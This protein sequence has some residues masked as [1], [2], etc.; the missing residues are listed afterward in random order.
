VYCTKSVTPPVAPLPVLVAGDEEAAP[1]GVLPAALADAVVAGAELELEVELVLHA[2]APTTRT[3]PKVAKRHLELTFIRRDIPALR[4]IAPSRLS[5][6]N[7]LVSGPSAVRRG[8]HRRR[9]ELID[10]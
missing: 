9:T 5:A 6:V 1:A 3:A 4:T 2:A 8:A 10:Q 7:S